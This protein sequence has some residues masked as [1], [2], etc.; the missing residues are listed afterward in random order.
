MNLKDITEKLIEADEKYAEKY[1]KYVPLEH[2]YQSRLNQ[3]VLSSQ[4]ASQPLREAEAM[5]AVRLE[6]IFEE[7]GNAVVEVKL[8]NRRWETLK[9]VSANIRNLA[10]LEGGEK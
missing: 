3:L 4:R 7:Y 6:P 8:A 10:F 9:V 1:T 2:A 5:E